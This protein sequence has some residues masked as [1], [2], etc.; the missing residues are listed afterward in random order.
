MEGRR[1][2]GGQTSSRDAHCCRATTSHPSLLPPPPPGFAAA[3]PRGP[4]GAGPPDGGPPRPPTPIGP[5]YIPSADEQAAIDD[6]ERTNCGEC[7]FWAAEWEVCADVPSKFKCDG[8]R[9]KPG[10]PCGPCAYL[11]NDGDGGHCVDVP[12]AV[13]ASEEFKPVAAPA[14]AP[15]SALASLAG[16]SGAPAAAPTASVAGL[17]RTA[18][19]EVLGST[20]A[21]TA[22]QAAVEEAAQDAEAAE[23]AAVDEPVPAPRRPGPRGHPVGPPRPVRD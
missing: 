10:K 7:R 3:Q 13:C 11:E 15:A 4:P 8:D 17:P 23:E 5:N 18:G 21:P 9:A 22:E 14:P 20:V 2:V 1:G 6:T 19:G 16:V 12:A